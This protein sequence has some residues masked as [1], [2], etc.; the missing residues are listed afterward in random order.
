[1][2]NQLVKKVKRIILISKCN[3]LYKKKINK[4]RIHLMIDSLIYAVLAWI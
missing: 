4:V 3:Q 2:Y 1:M